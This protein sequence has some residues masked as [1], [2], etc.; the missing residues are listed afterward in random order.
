[1]KHCLLIGLLLVAP[2]AVAQEDPPATLQQGMELFLDGLM[3]EMEPH[4]QDLQGWATQIGPAMQ[5]FLEEMGPAFAELMQEVE[6]WTA[7]HPPEILENGDIILRRKA[8]SAQE[9]PKPEAPSDP[10]DL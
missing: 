1:M 7:Y 3:E 4:L 8:P 6:D 2:P 9:G 10:I 5:G